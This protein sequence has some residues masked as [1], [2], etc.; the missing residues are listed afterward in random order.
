MSL[1]E[2]AEWLYRTADIY[3]DDPEIEAQVLRVAQ[4]VQVASG[5]AR[6]LTV[7]NNDYGVNYNY[8]VVDN[9]HLAK[10]CLYILAE[11]PDYEKER[12]R[13]FNEDLYDELI[14]ILETQDTSEETYVRRSDGAVI[15][16]GVRAYN[17]LT[18]FYDYD[19]D[20]SVEL[21]SPKV[22]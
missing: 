5:S 1:S 20:W 14:D 9:E 2:A 3:G 8:F 10:T 4:E 6:L 21:D 12:L 17:V 16:K 7:R 13:S 18:A 11:V 19:D 22:V 15:S